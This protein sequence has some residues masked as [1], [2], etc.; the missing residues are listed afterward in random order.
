MPE[1]YA[2]MLNPDRSHFYWLRRDG[3]ESAQH[4]NMWAIYQ[5]AKQDAADNA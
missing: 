2:L 3:A 4:W 1:G 5:W